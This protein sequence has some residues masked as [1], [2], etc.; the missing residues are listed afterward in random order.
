MKP[1]AC[2]ILFHA[3]AA[4]SL[5]FL[6]GQANAQL[7]YWDSNGTT[8]GF[9]TAGGT[10]GTDNFWNTSNTGGAGT[11]STSTTSSN[12]VNF[13]T[14]TNF[15]ASPATVAI[16][17]GGVTVNSIVYGSGQTTAITLGTA[18][19]NLTLAGST[20]TITVN[21]T[22]AH[23]A[24]L[25]PIVGTAGLTK[26]GAG[27]LV[28]RGS[29][30]YTGG[31][32]VN[33]GTLAFGTVAA[34][35]SGTHTFGAGTTLGL[36]FDGTATRF[37]AAEIQNAFAGTFTGNLAGISLDSTTNIAIDTTHAAQTFSANIGVSSRGLVKIANGSNL[38]LTGAN[39]YS[40]RTVVAGGSALIVN[41][42]GNIA[43]AS[44]N[45]GTNSTVDML[46]SSRI[47]IATTSSSNKHFNILGGATI[48]PGAIAFTHTGNISTETAGSKTLTLATNDVSLTD[49]KDFQGVIS[50]GSGTIAVTKISPGNIWLSGN[51]TYTGATNVNQG[52]LI[53]GHANALGG[54]ASGTTVSNGATLGLRNGIT[55]AAEA[56]TLSPGTSGNALLRNFSGNNTWSGTITASGG[57]NTNSRIGSDAGNLTLAGTVNITGTTHQL[58]LQGDGNIEIT[59][60]ITGS[61]FLSSATN[62]AGVRKLANDTNN[63]TGSTRANGGTLEFTSIANVGATSSA[64][65]AP[66]LADSVINLGFDTTDATLRYVG[67]APGGHTS[68]RV[69]R[70]NYIGTT[71]ANYSLQASGTGPLVLTSG[72]TAA[73]GSK[74]LT[75][76][77]TSTAANSIG[78]I[79]N[80]GTG[81][82]SVT[83]SGAGTWVLTGTNTYSGATNVSGGTLVVGN[84]ASINS[85]S[86]VTVDGGTFRYN[87]STNLTAP[88]TFTSGTVA[89]TN[90]SGIS[91]TVGTGRTVSP[92]NSP[93]TMNV[94]NQ[95]WA[96]GGTYLWELHDATSTA[97]TGWDLLA[98]TGTLDITASLGSEFTIDLTTLAAVAPDVLGNAINFNAN[99][100]Y[101]WLIADFA[102]VNGFNA[103]D[104]TIDATGFTNA[105]LSGSFGISLGGVGVVPGDSSQVYLTYTAIPEPGSALLGGLGFLAIL[106]RRRTV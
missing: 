32:T 106:R 82:I 31:T 3:L 77:G 22:R 92:G 25:S 72:V 42:L 78:P 34:K 99:S 105:P 68:D 49:V 85:S 28:L 45:I 98:G 24:I 86:G 70:L 91:L 73:N 64:L 47:D 63:F 43:D 74:T 10:W 38:T 101:A 41:S 96:A 36:G 79:A 75:L 54:T 18:G 103:T 90:L 17:S 6:S 2:P 58:V 66:A 84:A 67:T 48:F 57:A 95:T 93:G 61:S 29:N 50:N 7:L 102:A 69:V 51:S 80:G 97:G 87:A 30:S 88:L 27:T 5:L 11:F 55:T 1:K 8:S 15:A 56:L 20:P 33:A 89:G 13:G 104:F 19:N 21:N 59:G 9:G 52:N 62:G 76:S 37:T 4:S 81:A 83:K 65:G 14:G 16:A 100:S 39:Q 40:G 46:D 53:I 44:S 71:T 26:D 35:S 60:Q 94:A 12:T 23:Q